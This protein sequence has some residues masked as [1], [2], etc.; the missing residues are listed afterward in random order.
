VIRIEAYAKVNYGL[1]VGARRTDGFH[2][3]H[4]RFQS[5]A[6]AD[7]LT[8][9]FGES[10]AIVSERGGPVPSG[11]NNLAWLAVDAVR[12]AAQSHRPVVVTLDKKIPVAAGLGGGSADC[13]AALVAAQRLFGGSDELVA[14]LAAE[15]GSDVLFCLTGGYA[16]VSGRGESVVRLSPTDGYALAVVVP[17]VELSTVAV[18]DHWDEMGGPRGPSVDPKSVPTALRGDDFRNDLV[19]PA[20]ALQ[21]TVAEWQAELRIRWGRDVLMSGSGPSLFAFALDPGE[22]ADMI[23][24]TPVGARFGGIAEPVASG[25]LVLDEA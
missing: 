25:W 12:Q 16:E 17:P 10:D 1:R 22:A 7:E 3:I 24:G 23:D 14:D 18:Y 20:F 19:P 6:I 21:P 5:V 15:L 2:P 9:G 4:G 11:K 8:V 13:A